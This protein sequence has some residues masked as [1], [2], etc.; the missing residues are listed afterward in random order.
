MPVQCCRQCLPPF[1]PVLTR[2]LVGHQ[3]LSGPAMAPE[4]PAAI[5]QL[6]AVRQPG[7][8]G[9]EAKVVA[10]WLVDGQPRLRGCCAID[11]RPTVLLD[12]PHRISVLNLTMGSHEPTPSLGRPLNLS[13]SAMPPGTLLRGVLQAEVLPDDQPA[14]A[15]AIHVQLMVTLIRAIGLTNQLVRYD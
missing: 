15:Q 1:R 3:H 2:G 14:Q 9:V 6:D 7:P 10:A 11:L 5:D 4:A 13:E 12:D 8:H